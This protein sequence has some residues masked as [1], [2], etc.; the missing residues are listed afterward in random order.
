MRRVTIVTGAAGGVGRA[1]VTRLVGAG[2]AVVA[3]DIDPA[4]RE[5]AGDAVAV[6]EGDVTDPATARLAVEAAT[7]RFGRLD[8]LVNNAAR[9]STEPIDA[10]EPE[11]WDAILRTN[12]RGVYLHLRAAHAALATAHGAVVN[13]ASISGVIGLPNQLVYAATKGAV[14]QMTRT[15]AVEWAAEGIRV[16]AVAPGAIDTG[17]MDESLAGVPDVDRVRAAIAAGHP[18][19]RM[20]SPDEVARVIAFL[21]GDGASAMTGAVVPVDGGFTAT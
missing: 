20:S 5:L 21:L 18:L 8:G 9:F 13:V 12:T 17:F 10:L 1:L 7:T 4:V 15:I 2:Q 14:V 3:E 6:V 11:R 19:G 16:N